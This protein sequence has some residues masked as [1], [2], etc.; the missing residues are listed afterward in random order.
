MGGGDI[1]LF[2]PECMLKVV[3]WSYRVGRHL[4]LCGKRCAGQNGLP[5]PSFGGTEKKKVF[6][7]RMADS[8][9]P[10]ECS[11]A[12]PALT[13]QFSKSRYNTYIVKK[14][15]DKKGTLNSRFCRSPHVRETRKKLTRNP[16]REIPIFVQ[17]RKKNMSP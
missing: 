13:T 14:K 5:S 16:E 1:L 17:Y 9:C 4:G 7:S 3:K 15:W 11:F 8:F 12:R 6:T 10:R 2:T